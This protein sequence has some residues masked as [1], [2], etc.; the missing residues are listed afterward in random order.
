MGLA[1]TYKMV[2]ILGGRI[3]VE[4]EVGKGSVFEITIPVQSPAEDKLRRLFKTDSDKLA[5][6]LT[7][8]RQNL[9]ADKRTV[10]VI[11]DEE[12]A[13]YILRQYLHENGFQVIFP[14]NG[15]NV[16]ELARRYRPFAIT[17]DLLMPDQSGWDVLDIL[18]TNPDTRDIP[19][20]VASV[21]PEEQKAL[22]R[23]AAGYLQKP[24]EPKKLA[25]LLASLEERTTK[26]KGKIELPSLFSLK[27]LSDRKFFGFGR[28]APHVNG[29]VRILLV[30]DDLDTRYALRYALEEAGY[31][32]Y[33]ATD[34]E[35]AVKQAK[36]IQPRIILMDMMMPGVDGYE[37]TR[38]I[39]SRSALKHIPIIAITAKAMKGDRE[40]VLAAGCDDYI[41]KPFLTGE[42]LALVQK[43]LQ[44]EA[45]P[46]KPA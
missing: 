30:D 15:E 39:K 13:V 22:R 10:L 16:F 26:K 3:S 8:D 7:D 42:V 17:L 12:E 14:Q 36:E 24:V 32:V 25:E 29:T 35:A 44:A 34:G 37:A 11:D 46:E 20:I 4:S 43:W 27:K 23:G 1:I 21:L 2:E 38:Q 41:A 31:E 5:L 19:V 33:L 28:A 9:D 45:S 6:E 40:Q 18:Q